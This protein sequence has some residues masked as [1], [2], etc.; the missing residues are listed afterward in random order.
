MKHALLIAALT[1][2]VST[3]VSAEAFR[4]FY[5]GAGIGASEYDDD[6]YYDEQ[7]LDDSEVG[8]KVYGGYRFSKY[9]SLQAALV[10]LGNFEASAPDNKIE[11][12]A[13]VIT[14]SA[15]G[16]LPLAYGIA[17]YGELGVGYGTISQD[18]SYATPG[19]LLVT[20]DDDDGGLAVQYGAGLLIIPPDFKKLE[21]RVGWERYAFSTD[22]ISVDS[23]VRIKDDVDHEFD[24]IFV[25]VG[26]NFW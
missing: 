16:Q 9:L 10:G 14:L 15:L 23:G 26:L 12:E 4:G 2:L 8:G 20:D 3:A 11:N 19:G 21:F 1:T 5:V 25:G 6:G 22:T 13:S 18:I 7:R 17:L 24:M